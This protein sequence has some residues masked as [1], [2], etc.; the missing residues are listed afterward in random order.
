MMD[1]AE[2]PEMCKCGKNPAQPEH[3]CPY[4]AEFSEEPDETYCTC[5]D[6][7]MYE[8]AMDI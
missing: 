5:C 6:A 1:T 2:H 3:M 4:Q 7:C 8:C